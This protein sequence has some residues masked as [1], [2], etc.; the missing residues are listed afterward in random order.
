MTGATVVQG[1]FGFGAAG[2]TVVQGPFGAG[3]VAGVVVTVVAG[4][5]VTVVQGSAFVVGAGVVVTVVAGVVVTVVGAWVGATV[6]QG[7]AGAGGG[8]GGTGAA[9]AQGLAAMACPRQMGVISDRAWPS[10]SPCSPF[11]L[12]FQWGRPSCFVEHP[13]GISSENFPFLLPD[14]IV[15]K[16]TPSA[17][18]ALR[19]SASVAMRCAIGQ[20]HSPFAIA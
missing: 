11:F 10:F 5:V 19:H 20:Q 17:S 6:S 2:A 8:G 18:R 13:P 4:V 1:P 15:V 16:T 7:P 12:T 9:V 14:H 3:V